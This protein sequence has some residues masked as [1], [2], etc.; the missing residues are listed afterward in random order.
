VFVCFAALA[1]AGFGCSQLL[2][3]GARTAVLPRATSD[4]PDDV[5]GPQIQVVYALPADGT[6]R[7]LDENGP[8]DASVPS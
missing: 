2:A 6:D 7:D 3:A 8:L 1:G 4:R 5:S